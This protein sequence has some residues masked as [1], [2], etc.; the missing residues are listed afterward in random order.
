M[1]LILPLVTLSLVS[2]FTGGAGESVTMCGARAEDAE[3]WRLGDLETG[4]KKGPHECQPYAEV[5]TACKDCTAC[6]HCS[7]IGG[8]CSVCWKK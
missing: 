4:K 5:C 2:L 3:T 6:K 1:K 8:K 7:K